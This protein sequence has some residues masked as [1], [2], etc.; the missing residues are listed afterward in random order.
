MERANK[1]AVRKRITTSTFFSRWWFFTNPFEKCARPSNF[2][3]RIEFNKI[4]KDQTS[5]N[6]TYPSSSWSLQ[7][8]LE[9][10]PLS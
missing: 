8:Q 3:E 6:Q 10:I 5:T 4:E 2:R 1:H 7:Q 9:H